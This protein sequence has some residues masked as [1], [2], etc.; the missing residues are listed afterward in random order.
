MPWPLAE[1]NSIGANVGL[2]V[3]KLKSASVLTKAMEQ[4]KVRIVGALYDLDAGLVQILE[5]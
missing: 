3:A 4:D 5:A 1:M 2:T